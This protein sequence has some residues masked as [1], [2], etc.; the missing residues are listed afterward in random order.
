MKILV[1]SQYFWPESFRVNDLCLGL[2]ER[3]H[4]V[5]VLTSKPNYPK[6]DFYDGY[7]MF[8]NSEETWEGI[9]IIRSA[10]IRRKK[11][12]ALQLMINYLSFVFFGSIKAYFMKGQFDKI[13]VYGL[14][15]VTVGYPAIVAKRKFKIPI[16]FIVQDLWPESI[17]AASGLKNKHVLKV[18][19]DVT[20]Y[21][22][23]NSTQI[24]VQS[25][26][27]IPYILDQGVASDKIIYYP[28]SAENYYKIVKPDDKYKIKFPNN[29]GLNLLFAGNIGEAQSFDTL[30]KAALIIK[31][32][33]ILVNWVILGDGRLKEYVKSRIESLGLQ[34]TF[35]L[36]GSYPPKEMSS[37]FACADALLVSLKNNP[38]FSYTIP[39]KIQSYMACGKPI[40]ASLDGEGAKVVSE[41]E[42]GFSSP[43]EDAVALVDNIIRFSGLT[44]NERIKLGENAKNFFDK[45][46]EREFLL[47]KLEEI[48]KN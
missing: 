39:C 6:G 35:V 24:L 25:K 32:K 1:V 10:I 48:L 14:S 42:A 8:N 23:K 11:G 45:E 28:N 31:E 37:F 12:K 20:K 26:A 47:T 34:D 29:E 17:A 30:I 15:P 44:E 19:N 3:G 36:I 18:M 46:F 2:I 16:Y 38:I 7:T 13:L 22:Y 21:I 40:L 41:A 33:N 27:F 4:V 5:T 9:K 43:A